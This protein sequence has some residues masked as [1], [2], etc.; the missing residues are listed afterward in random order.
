MIIHY[1]CF[2]GSLFVWVWVWTFYH[3]AEENESKEEEWK[4]ERG[5]GFSGICCTE[6]SRP[7]EWCD[8]CGKGWPSLKEEENEDGYNPGLGANW[9][10]EYEDV[11]AHWT[12]PMCEYTLRDKLWKGAIESKRFAK[13][14]DDPIM[15]DGMCYRDEDNPMVIYM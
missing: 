11:G 7:D 10:D 13:L 9:M 6:S 12:I 8:N 3:L 15:K 2:S 5:T 1:I 14:F 4:W